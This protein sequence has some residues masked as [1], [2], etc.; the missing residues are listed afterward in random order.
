MAE[1]CFWD[2]V[3]CETVAYSAWGNGTRT[4]Y[5]TAVPLWEESLRSGHP[6][7]GDQ[8]E[9]RFTAFPST[10]PDD[11]PAGA[12]EMGTDNGED[13]PYCWIDFD[14]NESAAFTFAMHLES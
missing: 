9:P 10:L 3:E 5:K 11:L 12:V 2:N 8:S 7:L 14:E 1:P 6:A 13:G 4:I